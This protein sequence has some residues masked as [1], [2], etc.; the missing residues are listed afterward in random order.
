MSWE[1]LHIRYLSGVRDDLVEPVDVYYE[2]KSR[3]QGSGIASRTE[4]WDG[5]G[6]N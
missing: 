4:A 1:V 3:G 6:G 5:A 2:S